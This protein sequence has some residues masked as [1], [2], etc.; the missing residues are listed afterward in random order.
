MN[1]IQ[2][3]FP[4]LAPR[5]LVA[6]YWPERPC[7]GTG[8]ASRLAGLVDPAELGSLEETF[9]IRHAAA[10]AQGLDRQGEHV[11]EPIAP[12]AIAD[13]Y[14]AGRTIYLQDVQL[15]S[16]APWLA[17]IERE[18]AL[19]AGTI[20][21][22]LFASTAGAGTTLHY[23]S[24]EAFVVQVTGRKRWR[25]AA[26]RELRFPAGNRIASAADRIDDLIEVDLVPGTV[27]FLPR[28]CWHGTTTVE[29]SVH[30]DLAIRTPTWADVVADRIRQ[31]LLRHVQWRAPVNDLDSDARRAE[32][33]T[34]LERFSDDVAFD[35]T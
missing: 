4:A 27:L 12:T 13:A 17:A 9:A 21:V 33:A 34:L 25:Y 28:G 1:A 26:N 18:L 32:L 11:R 24:T 15:P 10:F 7:V 16:I 14:A 2:A 20:G 19:G 29:A 23:D 31:A 8:A 22:N 3:L 5:E 6:H 35:D 30:L